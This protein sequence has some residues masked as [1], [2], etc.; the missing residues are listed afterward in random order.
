MKRKYI[1][2][3]IDGTLTVGTPPHTYIPE[4]T[5]EALR[6]LRQNGH[7]VAIAT[8]R[9]QAMAEPIMKSLGFEH[10]VS[11]G[12]YGITIDGKLLEIRPLDKKKCLKLIEECQQKGFSWAISPD[13]QARRLAPDQR[14]YELTKDAYMATEV[15]ENL[16]PSQFDEIYKVYIA[17]Y[18]PEEQQLITLNELPWCRFHK[19]YLFVEPADKA[20]G[21]KR[22]VD[23][24]KG[25]YQDVIVFGD[26]KNDLSMFLDEW[27]CVA[28]GNAI[29]ELKEKAT[30]VTS[31]NDQDGIY[32]ACERLGLW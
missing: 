20:A 12:G 11:D 6:R 9:S 13:N 22:I 26:E 7:F 5:K 3:D 17:C 23:H 4:S 18:C 29:E 14:F 15:V 32:Q 24:L 30:L 16:D 27:T 21:I 28:M 19:E 31:N 25:N 8:G 2:F 10:M 1:F